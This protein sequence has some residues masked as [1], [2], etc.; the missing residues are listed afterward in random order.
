MKIKMS[1]EK[2]VQ[3]LYPIVKKSK[4]LQNSAILSNIW[5]FPKKKNFSESYKEFYSP[6]L[7]FIGKK[8]EFEYTI[9]KAIRNANELV[10]ICSFLLQETEIIKAALSICSKAKV[11]IITASENRLN[12]AN[13]SDE[14]L[15]EEKIKDHLEL[16]Q[17]LKK[18]ALIRT[19]PNFHA[20]FVL[21]DPK[22]SNKRKGF[23]STANLTQHALA[24]NVEMG[25][26]LSRGQ[27]IDLFNLFCSVFWHKS[28][29]ELLTRTQLQRTQSVPTQEIPEQVF[30][31]NIISPGTNL[32]FKSTLI[33]TISDFEGDIYI[34]AYSIEENNEIYTLLLQELE[35][36]PKRKISLF[37]RPRKKVMPVL[38]KL[39][40]AG[41]EIIGHPLLHMKALLIDNPTE[42][43]GIVFT[44]NLTKQSF[45]ESFDI[46][47]FLNPNQKEKIMTILKSWKSKYMMNYLGDNPIHNMV[48]RKYK[49]WNP[50]EMKIQVN[51]QKIEDLGDYEGENLENY[52]NFEP[53]INY[54]R[55][56]QYNTKNIKFLWKNHPPHLPSKAQPLEKLSEKELKRLPENLHKTLEQI[57]IYKNGNKKYIKLEKH[58]DFNLIQEISQLLNAKIVI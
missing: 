31:Q 53:P 34:S 36:N 8:R 46:G 4:E 55:K 24:N 9:A 15:E 43:S 48:A 28:E 23:L 12:S 41:A 32:D 3:D 5:E 16:L 25:I 45:S 39:K 22:N 26:G 38:A 54:P 52:P 20:K 56:Y 30:L 17:K 1:E 7:W 47:V 58:E 57:K 44:G 40:K 18:K 49:I 11:Y 21:I 37:I 42:N 19:A 6:D 2:S 10:I 27:I 50:D 33:K 13:R 51:E 29:H 14:G 35:K